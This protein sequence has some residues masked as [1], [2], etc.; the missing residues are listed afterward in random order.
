MAK[1][2]LKIINGQSLR[3]DTPFIGTNGN[4]WIGDTDTGTPA[5]Q[6]LTSLNNSVAKLE[7]EA[8]KC[9]AQTLEEAKKTQ[10]RANIGAA[11]AYTY[12][13]EYIE[14][15]SASTEPTGTLHFIYE[16]VE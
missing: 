15:G 16:P 2:R 12:G 9:T 10:A 14:A 5:T 4:W 6:D 8:V 1:A 3:G 13:T 11:P 7:G